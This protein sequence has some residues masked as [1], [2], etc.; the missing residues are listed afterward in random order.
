M[1]R[2]ALSVVAK[3]LQL[4]RC[5]PQVWELALLEAQRK[6]TQPHVEYARLRCRQLEQLT[7]GRPDV[8]NCAPD[9]GAVDVG[10]FPANDLPEPDYDRAQV[11]AGLQRRWRASLIEGG[12]LLLCAVLLLGFSAQRSGLVGVW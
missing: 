4:H 7:Q 12:M 11:I 3:E 10:G 2:K 1:N 9:L 5:K 8:V 6:R